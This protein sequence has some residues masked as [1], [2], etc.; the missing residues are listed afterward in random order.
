[1][2]RAPRR[3]RWA[4]S[5]ADLCLL[6]LGFFVLLQ[7]HSKR[8]SALAGINAYFRDGGTGARAIDADIPA[9]MLFVP[10]E[11][12][13]TPAGRAHLGTIVQEA[14]ESGGVLRISSQGTDP[15]TARF[16]GWDLASARLGAVA[17]ALIQ[18]GLPPERIR[19]EGPDS[20]FV[21]GG[22]AQTLMIRSEP[23]PR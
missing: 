2:I 15:G 7:A 12:M 19:I 3:A 20:D 23:A 10:N 21:Q 6:L 16:D 5:F 9:T 11:A 13:L 18:A 8:D 1:M 14:R 17:R 22:K 4:L